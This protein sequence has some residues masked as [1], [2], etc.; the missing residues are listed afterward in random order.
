MGHLAKAFALRDAPKLVKGVGGAKAPRKKDGHRLK[1]RRPNVK[2]KID[3]AK[4]WDR[5][6]SGDAEKRMQAIVRAQGRLTKKSGVMA[7]TGASEFQISGGYD[8]EKLVGKS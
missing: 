7:S 4:E 2:V 1:S 5:D 3:Q 6:H 8:L